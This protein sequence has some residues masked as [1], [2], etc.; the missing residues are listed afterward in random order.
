MPGPGIR[1]ACEVRIPKPT[2]HPARQACFMPFCLPTWAQFHSS[3]CRQTS[4]MVPTPLPLAFQ[5][6][7]LASVIDTQLR[8]AFSQVASGALKNKTSQAGR[9]FP[10]SSVTPSLSPR[11]THGTERNLQMQAGGRP[12]HPRIGWVGTSKAFGKNDHIQAFF[13]LF[14]FLFFFFFLLPTAAF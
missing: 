2:S 5:T 1:P 6:A 3:K 10:P 8:S 4:S 9:P 14:L 7:W 13:F 11:A 12:P